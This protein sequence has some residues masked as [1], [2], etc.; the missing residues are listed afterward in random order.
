MPVQGLTIDPQ[1]LRA[2]R[3]ARGLRREEVA[4]GIG[5]SYEMVALLE[6]G[7]ARPSAQTLR[8]LC[9]VL[10]CGPEVLGAAPFHEQE[11]VS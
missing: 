8:R 3:Q 7:E 11:E 10:A 4:V 5:R 9:R 2:L 1:R 6:R